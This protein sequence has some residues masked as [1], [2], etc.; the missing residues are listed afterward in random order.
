[1]N[2]GNA[3]TSPT[4]AFRA[5]SDASLIFAPRS[6]ETVFGD[7]GSILIASARTS[8]YGNNELSAASIAFCLSPPVK[9]LTEVA[10]ARRSLFISAK[11]KPM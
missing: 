4:H 10:F 11:T 3:T 7:R 9:S 2:A 6:R 5:T 8:A 1:V